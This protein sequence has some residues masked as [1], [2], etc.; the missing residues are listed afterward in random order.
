MLFRPDG[1]GTAETCLLV[2]DLLSGAGLLVQL[3]WWFCS[4]ELLFGC[5]QVLILA[6]SA[7]CSNA[8]LFSY[9]SKSLIQL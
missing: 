7:G 6:D 8:V 3:S 1:G 2:P 9:R 4:D 5:A